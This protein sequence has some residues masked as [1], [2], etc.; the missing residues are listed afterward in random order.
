MT[1]FSREPCNKVKKIKLETPK[2][3]MTSLQTAESDR[4]ERITDDDDEDPSSGSEAFEEGDLL[5]SAMEDDVT[6][7]LAAAGWQYKHANGDFHFFASFSTP[8]L[9]NKLNSLNNFYSISYDL[10]SSI[11]AA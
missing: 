2:E 5:A 8:F 6:A 9:S 11:R 4:T 7:Q 3:E 1:S 10:S